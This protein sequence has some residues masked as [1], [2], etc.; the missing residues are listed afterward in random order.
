MDGT[1]SG[2]SNGGDTMIDE[3]NKV[4]FKKVTYGLIPL[5]LLGV[6]IYVLFREGPLA[7]FQKDLPPV[8]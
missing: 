8:E 2:S 6:V 5:I 3:S 4:T 1:I 7:I